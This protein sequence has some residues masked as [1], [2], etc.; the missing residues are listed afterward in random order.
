[1]QNM[2]RNTLTLSEDAANRIT[3]IVEFTGGSIPSYVAR[4]AELISSLPTTEQEALHIQIQTRITQLR[5][6][7]LLAA[8][9]VPG[10]PMQLQAEARTLRA[11]VSPQHRRAQKPRSHPSKPTSK[12]SVLAAGV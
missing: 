11:Q 4:W 8:P 9:S 10:V 3:R 12:A 5:T 7:G 6:A 1:M 2:H